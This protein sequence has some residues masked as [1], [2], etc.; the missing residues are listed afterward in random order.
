[1]KDSEIEQEII[2][3]G[4]T[5]PRVTTQTID[6]LVGSLK[7]HSWQVPETTTTLVAAELDDGFIVAIGKAASVSKEN[8]NA[9]IGYKI[10]RDDAE[11]KARDKLW[12]LK[13]WELKQNL[14]QGM[15]A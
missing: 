15:A 6:E 1:M 13:G 10:A 2:E 8:F 12:E 14:K 3:K 11:R 7:Y 4:L 5:A 9:E